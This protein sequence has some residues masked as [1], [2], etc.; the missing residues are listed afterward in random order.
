MQGARVAVKCVLTIDFGEAK[1]DEQVSGLH[2]EV[3]EVTLDD[4]L[5]VELHELPDLLVDP[6]FVGHTAVVEVDADEED[7]VDDHL[8][9]AILGV[10]LVCR[11]VG[12]DVLAAGGSA[13]RPDCTLVVPLLLDLQVFAVPGLAQ[14][15]CVHLV[16]LQDVSEKV[17]AALVAMA[18]EGCDYHLAQH[19]VR[20]V[21][22]V[23]SFV[24]GLLHHATGY[25]H[26]RVCLDLHRSRLHSIAL[27]TS[28][29]LEHV[30]GG[31]DPAQELGVRVE[32]CRDAEAS[33]VAHEAAIAFHVH[34]HQVEALCVLT[35]DGDLGD[36]LD[37]LA[38]LGVLV[39][40]R[41]DRN[42]VLEGVAAQILRVAAEKVLAS[43]LKALDERLAHVEA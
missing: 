30:L 12:A 11:L 36:D 9:E 34:A 41:N 29:V 3:V 23:L 25:V 35:V 6:E 15:A 18:V 4:N 5:L 28:V 7:G 42:D 26:A 39:A 13:A 22:C 8:D 16:L 33:E 10:F 1:A 37:C 38:I 19:N 43:D 14:N 2:L 20:G 31:G 27:D 17:E 40:H 32:V 24:C 21:A